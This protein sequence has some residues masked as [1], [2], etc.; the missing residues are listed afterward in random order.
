MVMAAGCIYDTSFSCM[1]VN[2]VMN[3]NWS[4]RK[5][6]LHLHS[7]ARVS[8]HSALSENK[9]RHWC[10]S[11][12]QVAISSYRYHS[13]PVPCQ[14]GS[15]ETTIFILRISVVDMRKSGATGLMSWDEIIMSLRAWCSTVSERWGVMHLHR[16]CCW[17][18]E[19]HI[20]YLSVMHCVSC[21]HGLKT[22]QDRY[23]VAEIVV[24]DSVAA[25]WSSQTLPGEM[26]QIIINN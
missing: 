21:G 4:A 19:V 14:N 22:K 7:V 11:L 3:H 25:F 9:I 10:V 1:R 20:C 2:G 5:P 18:A 15:L 24:A 8:C 26:F 17:P 23:M 12:W 6:R 16:L 13:V